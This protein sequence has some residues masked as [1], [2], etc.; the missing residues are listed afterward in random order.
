MSVKCYLK[1]RITT[2]SVLMNGLNGVI[3][4]KADS[5][6]AFAYLL[7]CVKHKQMLSYDM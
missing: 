6:K 1:I 7:M 4:T 3:C 2:L 5:T